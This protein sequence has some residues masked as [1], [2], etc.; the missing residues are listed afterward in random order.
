M[1]HVYVTVCRRE[2]G[3]SEPEEAI[4]DRVRALARFQPEEKSYRSLNYCYN[5]NVFYKDEREVNI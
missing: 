5:K 2:E 1:Y 4:L 3:E